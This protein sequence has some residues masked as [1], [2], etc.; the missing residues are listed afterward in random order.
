[1]IL[2]IQRTDGGAQTRI[3]EGIDTKVDGVQPKLSERT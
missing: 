1:M 2:E 3:I